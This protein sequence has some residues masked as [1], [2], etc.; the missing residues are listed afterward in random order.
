MKLKYFL[1]SFLYSSQSDH[2][3]LLTAHT[4]T[5]TQTHTHTTHGRAPLDEG[6]DRRKPD[7]AQHSQ[8]RKVQA[9]S[10]IRNRHPCN[11]AAADSHQ[12]S[13]LK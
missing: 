13:D 4:Q 2:F 3:Y 8:D 10:G 1:L 5:Q 11:L 9:V 12:G 6:S 7:K